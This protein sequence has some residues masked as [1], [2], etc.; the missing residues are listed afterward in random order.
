MRFAVLSDIHGND[1]ALDTCIGNKEE[2]WFRD[3]SGWKEYDSTTGYYMLHTLS[4]IERN[5]TDYIKS[6]GLMPGRD[7]GLHLAGYPGKI[8]GIGYKRT[9]AAIKPLKACGRTHLDRAYGYGK[10]ERCGI[11]QPQT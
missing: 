4:V 8:L 2:Y 6:H 7:R 5:P 9:A 3:H 1:I 10:S 11:G